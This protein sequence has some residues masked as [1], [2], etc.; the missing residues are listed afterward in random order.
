MF[1]SDSED[2]IVQQG[3]KICREAI[4]CN[5][6]PFMLT[7]LDFTLLPSLSEV[8]NSLL[9]GMES[10]TSFNLSTKGGLTFFYW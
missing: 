4:F 6:N 1:I 10:D 5:Q 8:D 2:E 7:T 9:F 3:I